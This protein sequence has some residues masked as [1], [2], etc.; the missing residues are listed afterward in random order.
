MPPL[1]LCT[2]ETELSVSADSVG[3][4][5]QQAMRFEMQRDVLP[6]CVNAHA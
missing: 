4:T 5:G 1:T 3:L 6:V 2:D